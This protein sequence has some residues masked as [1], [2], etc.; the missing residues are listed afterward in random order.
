MKRPRFTLRVLM[1]AVAVAAL[2]PWGYTLGRRS[3]AFA[4]K[5]QECESKAEKGLIPL[6]ASGFGPPNDAEIQ[7]IKRH[8]E[9]NER[10]KEHHRRLALKYRRA[11]RFPWLPV[12]PD[13]PEPARPIEPDPPPA[14]RRRPKIYHPPAT[15]LGCHTTGPDSSTLS[16]SRA[17]WMTRITSMPSAAGR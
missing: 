4:A 6:R 9:W 1:I 8:N 2:V 12:E 10:F 16:M 7:L 17:P 11:A 13:P 14:P 5:A 15:V 3:V